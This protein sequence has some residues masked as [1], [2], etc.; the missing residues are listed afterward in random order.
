MKF[1]IVGDSCTDLPREDL[2]KPYMESVPLTITIGEYEV[3]DD[4]TFE[5]SDFLKR[6]AQYSG[7]PKSACPSPEVY[8][9]C[10]EDAEEI[11]VVVLSAKLSGSYN[12]AQ[13]AKELYQQEHPKVRI[14]V[15][16]SKSAAAGQYLLAKKIEEYALAGMEF[17]EVVERV[18][19]FREEMSTLFVLESLDTLRKNGRLTGL[20]S[21]VAS[22]LNIK[23]YMHG[24][25]GM[26]AQL[27][28]ARGMKKAINCMI[29]H[30]GTVGGNLSEKTAVISHCNC[31]GRAKEVEQELQERYQF[32]KTIILPTRGI[33]SLYANDG[34]IIVSF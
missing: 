13:L 17:E 30:I 25:D 12:S 19:E 21:V 10:F 33:S 14:H 22:A 32:Q 18:T 11:Y 34:G 5:Q 29:A 28:Q 1:K 27:G 24:E 31:F 16:D 20:K 15:F 2:E 7:C 3:V 9:K 6:V 26:I 8:M 23:P 4:D